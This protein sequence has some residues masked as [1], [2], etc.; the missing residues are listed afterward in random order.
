M[1]QARVRP[2]VGGRFTRGVHAEIQDDAPC[3][4]S[5]QLDVEYP[6]VD[7]SCE[8]GRAPLPASVFS[9]LHRCRKVLCPEVIECDYLF[10]GHLI[11][12]RC[13][14]FAANFWEQQERAP[15]HDGR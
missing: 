10:D 13:V 3:R 7:A 11:R 6:G 15:L 8:A 5:R 9:R 12:R 2:S 14:R 4:H 1:S